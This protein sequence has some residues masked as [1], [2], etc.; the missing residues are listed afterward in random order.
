VRGLGRGAGFSDVSFSVHAGEIV[1]MFG[2]IG[3]G[4]TEVARAIFG[5]DPPTSGEILIGGKPVTVSS[6]V[7]AVGQGI[8]L[9]TEDRKRDGLALDCSVVDNVGL[10]STGRFS[11]RGI[12]DRSR[13]RKAVVRKLDELSVRPRGAR[14]PVRRLSG[15]NQQKVVLSKWLLV[16][17]IR[18]F[19]FDEPTRGVDIATKFEIYRMMAELAAAGRAILFISSEMPEVLGLSD[20]VIVM[21]GGRIAGQFARGAAGMETLFAAAA[22]VEMHRMPA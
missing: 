3:S 7:E 1:G 2:L 21:R 13:Q 15:G 18:I 22:G 10:A 16:D 19:I 11:R 12:L 9:V 17:G 20:R 6:P 4:R 5:A 8:A 14:G